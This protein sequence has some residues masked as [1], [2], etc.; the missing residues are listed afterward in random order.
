MMNQSYG[1]NLLSLIIKQDILMR[2]FCLKFLIY[3]LI[4]KILKFC[5]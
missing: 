4:I 3:E 5:I 2:Y 1:K